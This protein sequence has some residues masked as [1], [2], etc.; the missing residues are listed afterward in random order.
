MLLQG[1]VC[2]SGGLAACRSGGKSSSEHPSRLRG[3][4]G[5]SREISARTVNEGAMSKK[6]LRAKAVPGLGLRG[7]T[8]L[9]N[10]C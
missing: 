9:A 10:R 4:N 5:H 8:I 7:D 1:F 2:V 3:R 6:L